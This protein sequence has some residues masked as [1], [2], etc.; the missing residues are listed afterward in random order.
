MKT[1]IE[2]ASAVRSGGSS[3]A[4][5]RRNAARNIGY[6]RMPIA[7][8][9]FLNAHEPE[10]AIGNWRSA[11]KLLEALQCFCF[12]VIGIED[13]KQLCNYQQI[14]NLIRQLQQFKLATL[15]T[16]RRVIRN[17]LPDTARVDIFN[18]G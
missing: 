11:M 4:S 18:P 5:R 1:P 6:C 2:K 12:V 9:Q 14:L 15:T 8:C 10:L 13:G 3:I 7:D 16:D 17:Q